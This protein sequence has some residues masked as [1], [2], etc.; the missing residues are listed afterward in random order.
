MLPFEPQ[1]PWPTPGASDQYVG[2][3][4]LAD[5]NVQVR[6][7]YFVW[8]REKPR[9][10]KENAGYAFPLIWAK[11]VKAGSRC[12]PAGKNGD[13]IDFVVFQDESAAIVRS[14][15]AILQRTTNDKQPRRLIASVVAPNVVNDWGGFVTEN[16]TILLTGP[17]YAQLRLVVALLNTKAVD[18]RYRKVSGTAAISVTLLRTL[19]LPPLERF[20]A[21]FKMT[22]DAEVAANIAYSNTALLKVRR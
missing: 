2:G 19:D 4:T 18:D 3:A 22:G 5:Y 8:N 15:A 14:A 12:V 11:N 13:Q 16:H 7:G 10:I 20:K 17:S 9:L 1:K 21:A 6:A